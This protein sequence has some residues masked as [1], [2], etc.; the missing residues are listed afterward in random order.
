MNN[1]ADNKIEILKELVIEHKVCWDLWPEYLHVKGARVQIGFELDLVGIHHKPDHLPCPGCG[2]CGTVYNALKQIALWIM[3][4]EERASRYDIQI[5]DDS[6]HY[7]PIR[8]L[9]PDVTLAIKILHRDGFDKPV[10]ACEVKCLNEM[11]EKLRKLGA[12][13]GEW[14]SSKH[15][16]NK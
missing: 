12:W 11:E 6:L 5:F 15:S 9:R 2:E 10:D 4:H 8:D 13:K 3:P 16:Q 7:A 14:K 1:E